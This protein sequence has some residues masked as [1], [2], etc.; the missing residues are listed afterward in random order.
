MPR[1][2][3]IMLAALA[4]FAVSAVASASASATTLGWDV[5]GAELLGN[6]PISEVPIVAPNDFTLR[7]A[8]IEISCSEVVVKGGLIEPN[9]N[10]AKA[11]LFKDTV[12][13]EGVTKEPCDVTNAE[14]CEVVEPIETH[15]IS[16]TPESGPPVRVKFKPKV[17]GP[18]IT[19]TL[20]SKAGH[21]CLQ[22]KKYEVTGTVTCNV[23]NGETEEVTKT[24]E[25]TATSGSEIKVAGEAGE[26]IGE[27]GV[28]LTSGA[29]F[30]PSA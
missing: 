17:A 23:H 27:A 26:F 9:S 18:F 15:E 28:K 19:L 21:T 14:N 6:E 11:L 8:G 1:I 5:N 3:L 12:N 30:A 13:D 24:L 25:C 22:A 4:V 16:S 29:K 20:K 7:G 2:R 10:S